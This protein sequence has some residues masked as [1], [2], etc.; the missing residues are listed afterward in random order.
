M[1]WGVIYI[2][3]CVCAYV[4]ALLVMSDMNLFVSCRL[5]SMLVTSFPIV[6]SS[7]GFNICIN[8][9]CIKCIKNTIL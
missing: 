7:D 8:C 4:I 2:Y 3:I 9:V 1:R 6:A 5:A